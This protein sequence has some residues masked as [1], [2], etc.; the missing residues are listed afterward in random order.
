[1]DE[2]YGCR[3][4]DDDYESAII[5]VD[6]CQKCDPVN[7]NYFHFTDLEGVTIIKVTEISPDAI[8]LAL[9]DGREIRIESDAGCENSFLIISSVK[10]GVTNERG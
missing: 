6:S 4:C 2:L 1:M 9:E 3:S 8:G 7:T 10:R 5:K